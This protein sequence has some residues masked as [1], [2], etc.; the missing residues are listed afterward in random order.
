MS[1]K[2]EGMLHL[3]FRVV[4]DLRHTWGPDFNGAGL[5]HPRSDGMGWR[6]SRA[7]RS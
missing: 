3:F 4:V 2:S 7:A 6:V 1:K 5:T